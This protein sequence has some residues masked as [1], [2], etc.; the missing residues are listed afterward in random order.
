MTTKNNKTTNLFS[1]ISKE[2]IDE[3]EE[4]YRSN[5]LSRIQSLEDE[6][7]GM[8]IEFL[9]ENSDYDENED[10]DVDV[11]LICIMSEFNYE[12]VYG[13]LDNIPLRDIIHN[14]INKNKR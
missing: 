5:C 7:I 14:R 2:K 12:N 1:K 8:M 10:Y 6:C 4:Q 9:S 3:F 11:D 13:V